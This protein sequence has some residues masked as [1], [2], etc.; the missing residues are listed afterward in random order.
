M[1]RCALLA[2]LL[3]LSLFGYSADRYPFDNK[4]Q[5]HEFIQ[6]TQ[7]L[8][9]L[10]CQNENLDGSNA[11]LASDLKHQVYLMVKQGQSDVAIKQYMV[12]RYGDFVL[13]KPRWQSTTWLLWCFP[14]GALVLALVISV[15]VVHKRRV[16]H[17][18]RVC[19]QQQDK[20]VW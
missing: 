20:T 12:V 19:E 17:V 16:R 14:V 11:P 4:Q 1:K 10:V 7:Q 15:Y 5:Q 2:F 9:C 18:Q 8:R 6:L 3:L 13:F